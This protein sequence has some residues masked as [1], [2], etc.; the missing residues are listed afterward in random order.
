VV[1]W[2]ELAGEWLS[3]E[4]GSWKPASSAPELQWQP[5]RTWSHKHRSWGTYGIESHYQ[6]RTG[7]D[8][9]DWEDLEHAEVQCIVN[10]LVTAKHLLVVTTCKCSIKPSTNPNPVY[11]HPNTWQYWTGYCSKCQ[12][13]LQKWNMYNNKL[14][15]WI[16]PCFNHFAHHQVVHIVTHCYAMAR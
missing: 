12:H 9:A 8:T 6:T 14:F 15:V 11:S 1:E 3:W 13:N 7:E 10:E 5:A 16:I 4:F 2:S